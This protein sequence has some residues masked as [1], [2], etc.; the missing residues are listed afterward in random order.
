MTHLI[1][2]SDRQIYWSIHSQSDLCTENIITLAG[3]YLKQSTCITPLLQLSFTWRHSLDLNLTSDHKAAHR[4]WG[5]F[6]AGTADVSR[7][8]PA[9]WLGSVHTIKRWWFRGIMQ[10]TSLVLMYMNRWEVRGLFSLSV[11]KWTCSAELSFGQSQLKT[12]YKHPPLV[13]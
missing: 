10:L 8:V 3:N 7:G 4:V 2:C 5:L 12:L 11:S 6:G 1:N 13:V 9:A